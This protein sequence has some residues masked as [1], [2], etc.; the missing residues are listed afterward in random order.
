MGLKVVILSL[1]FLTSIGSWFYVLKFQNDKYIWLTPRQT[2][3]SMAAVNH[4]KD[5][6]YESPVRALSQKY[7]SSYV[8]GFKQDQ[9]WF[10][11]IPLFAV[12]GQDAK[13]NLSCLE[14]PYMTLTFKAK[15][16]AISGDIPK[17][18]VKTSCQIDGDNLIPVKIPLLVLKEKF[19][20]N[21]DTFFEDK[22]SQWQ[23]D[24]LI[25]DWPREWEFDQL[26][27]N[28]SKKLS[29]NDLIFSNQE[30]NRMKKPIVIYVD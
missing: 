27:F 28:A 1:F 24:G 8:K 20:S 19:I 14:Y 16:M 17:L 7:F 23:I 18:I 26:S 11:K 13:W 29:S 10:I 5:V 21:R 2:S 3:R 25:A 15:N 30:L 4:Q 9:D 6:S 22:Q 12:A